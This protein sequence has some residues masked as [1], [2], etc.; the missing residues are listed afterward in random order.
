[1]FRA[2][3]FS[4]VALNT[5]AAVVGGSVLDAYPELR[6]LTLDD[7]FDYSWKAIDQW[8]CPWFLKSRLNTSLSVFKAGNCSYKPVTVSANG[9]AQD[10]CHIYD[11]PGGPTCS[12]QRDISYTT[13]RSTMHGWKIGVS[14]KFGDSKSN[15]AGSITETSAKTDGV[16][17]GWNNLDPGY[18]YVPTISY[19]QVSCTGI[20][21]E[22]EPQIWRR[23]GRGYL[24]NYDLDPPSD[25]WPDQEMEIPMPRD[26]LCGI[27]RRSSWPGYYDTRI[28]NPGVVAILN[29]VGHDLWKPQMANNFKHLWLDET[30]DFPVLGGDGHILSVYGLDKRSCQKAAS[31]RTAE[32][33]YIDL[34]DGADPESEE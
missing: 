16:S 12:Y 5:I 24:E 18:T 1:M 2:A 28:E 8:R 17:M 13:T 23:K 15:R 30:I 32:D 22:D 7:K 21:Y 20:V 11:N 19:L 4:L 25:N 10:C 9:P 26:L 3:L 31:M 33:G 14:A 27:R 6:N 29:L 34:P